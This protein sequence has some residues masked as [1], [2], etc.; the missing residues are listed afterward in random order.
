[1]QVKKEKEREMFWK[2][3]DRAL[4]NEFV[5]L[6]LLVGG[7][8]IFLFAIVSIAYALVGPSGWELVEPPRPGLTCWMYNGSMVWCEP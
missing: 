1:M 5:Q 4:S 3:A 2:F 7:F 6:L 8:L